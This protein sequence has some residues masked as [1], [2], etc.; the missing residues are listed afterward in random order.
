MAALP[1]SYSSKSSVSVKDLD[2]AEGRGVL[3]M[4]LGS[5]SRLQSEP[6]GGGTPRGKKRS[7]L[8]EVQGIL[9]E[10]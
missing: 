10:K 4:S 7:G 3:V 6:R 9:W 8:S 5:G 2:Q 1:C